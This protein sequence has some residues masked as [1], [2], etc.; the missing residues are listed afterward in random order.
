VNLPT[1]AMDAH[2]KRADEPQCI[3]TFTA[4]GFDARFFCSK[5]RVKKLVTLVCEQ[6]EAANKELPAP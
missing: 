3:I 5:A 1:E 4:P 2:F 6:I